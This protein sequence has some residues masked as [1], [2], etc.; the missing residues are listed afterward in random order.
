MK[1]LKK[2]YLKSLCP[3]IRWL[4]KWMTKKKV[5]MYRAYLLP[6][7]EVEQGE[8]N[9]DTKCKIVDTYAEKWPKYTAKV[10]AQI[11]EMINGAPEYKG[12]TDLDKIRTDMR[13][14][15]Y[16]YGFLPD[17]YVF[18]KLENMG[19]TERRSFVSDLDRKIFVF[20]A[21]DFAEMY[22]FN[23]KWKSYELLKKYYKREALVVKDFKEFKAFVERHPVFVKKRVELFK[24]MG[25][26][27]VDSANCGKSIEELFDW[28]IGQGKCVV[29]ERIQQSSIMGAF[30]PESVNTLRCV[31]LNTKNGVKILPHTFLKT[32]RKGSFVDN[33]G[34]GG[35]LIGI[36]DATGI[37]DTDGI[38]EL[39]NVYTAHP[40]SGV[41]YKGFQIPDWEQ[42]TALCKEAA[43]NV[44]KLK[45]C[46]WDVAHTD[47]GWVVV[48]VNA[49]GQ[50]VGQQATIGHGIKADLEK[51]MNEMDLMA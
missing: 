1:A 33:G 44:S 2:E 9:F 20:R 43:K 50:M 35:I 12:R 3:N 10:D 22:L 7:H 16:A 21:N 32:G 40:D 23:D 11:E 17:E 26:E 31:T 34:A 41:V 49:G 47:K 28:I 13:F 30:N 6:E 14:C 51:L 4:R 37:I 39:G 25:V 19:M 48:E 8:G 5:N 24:G 29:E 15:F 27:L 36:D 46:G 38:D 18:F 42:M 45:Y